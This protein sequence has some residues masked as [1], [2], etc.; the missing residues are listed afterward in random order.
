M[1]ESPKKTAGEGSAILG[2]GEGGGRKTN[3]SERGHRRARRRR[4]ERVG[5]DQSEG[6]KGLERKKRLSTT[7][8]EEKEV[9]RSPGLH[10]R[11]AQDTQE[12][13]F[14]NRM[15]TSTPGRNV[16]QCKKRKRQYLTEGKKRQMLPGGES[17]GQPG[18]GRGAA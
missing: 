1:T 17:V 6:D 3:Y 16:N 4:E 7:R 14:R 8:K 5:Q 9:C 13:Q 11:E 2:A 15:K 10:A 12:K 18:P